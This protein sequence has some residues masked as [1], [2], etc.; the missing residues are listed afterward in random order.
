M[1]RTGRDSAAV[2]AYEEEFATVLMASGLARMM[3]RVLVCLY[4]TDAGGLTAAELAARLENIARF[5]DFVS[6]GILRS[7]EQ[8]REVLS[9]Q[10]A[11]RGRAVRRVRV[12]R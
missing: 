3:S 11:Y 6:E 1:S 10:G 12:R 5:L 2:L 7:A 9:T 8:A 4:T